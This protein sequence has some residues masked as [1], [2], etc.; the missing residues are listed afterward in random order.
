MLTPTITKALIPALIIGFLPQPGLPKPRVDQFQHMAWM[1]P[2]LMTHEQRLQRQIP[3]PTA[4]DIS[5][6]IV[7]DAQA[8][9]LRAKVLLLTSE[10]QEDV[11]IAG[12]VAQ[13]A[14]DAARI[15]RAQPGDPY[16]PSHALARADLSLAWLP[17]DIARSPQVTRRLMIYLLSFMA[18]ARH[19]EELVI[20]PRNLVPYIDSSPGPPHPDSEYRPPAHT[21]HAREVTRYALLNLDPAAKVSAKDVQEL[22]AA[23]AD[24]SLG[25]VKYIIELRER[26]T[27]RDD[28][29]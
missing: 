19:A 1:L 4:E 28:V 25:G 2:E 23:F 16:I 29:P 15:A 18:I 11:D 6:R 13:A 8:L 20:N 24:Q 17:D 5:K 26:L 9:L 14:E 22:E 3:D 10:E 12:I 27:K 21:Y 7:V